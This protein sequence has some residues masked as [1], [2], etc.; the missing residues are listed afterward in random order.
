MGSE[1]KVRGQRT[2]VVPIGA[3]VLMVKEQSLCSE[4]ETYVA[5]YQS[6]DMLYTSLR[7]GQSI[8]TLISVFLV[9]TPDVTY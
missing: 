9:H 1:V 8:V 7:L 5:T 4:I 3:R 2:K 6:F